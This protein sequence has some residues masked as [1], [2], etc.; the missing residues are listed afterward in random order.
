MNQSKK[1]ILFL[2]LFVISFIFL[3]SLVS[4]DVNVTAPGNGTNFSAL[5][6]SGSGL[7]LFNVTF[8]NNTDILINGTNHIEANATFYGF[9]GTGYV[10]TKR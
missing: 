8:L 9:N 2:P 7:V 3:L 1:I 5:T 4:A 10:K 6:S